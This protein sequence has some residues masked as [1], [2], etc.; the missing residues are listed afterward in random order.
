MR[1]SG[2]GVYPEDWGGGNIPHLA[3]RGVT[4]AM[5]FPSFTA[6]H[7][8]YTGCSGEGYEPLAIYSPREVISDVTEKWVSFEF[9]RKVC[10]PTG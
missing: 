8:A 9:V 6:S 4:R 3:G 7:T 1:L 10:R 2:E 5:R